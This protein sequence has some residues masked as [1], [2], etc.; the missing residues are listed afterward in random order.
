MILHS[1]F[2]L[3]GFL[4]MSVNH[5]EGQCVRKGVRVPNVKC[6]RLINSQLDNIDNY[7]YLL[8]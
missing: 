7:C 8:I 4:Q 1:Y 6:L 5:M 3:Y 2:D